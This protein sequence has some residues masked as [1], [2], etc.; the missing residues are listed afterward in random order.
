MRNICLILFALVSFSLAHAQYT[1]KE[2]KRIENTP[3]KSQ[4]RTGTCW[5]FATSSFLESE[6]SRL[7]GDKVDLSE[8]Y[9]VKQN[10]RDKAL[11]Y[12]LRQGNARFSQG[13]LS[14]DVIRIAALHGLVPQQQLTGFTFN[15]KKYDH[16]ELASGLKGYLDGV[17]K[18]R[19]ITPMWD[20][21]VDA[22]LDIYIG[23]EPQEFQYKGE[24]YTPKSFAEK[25]GFKAE[26]YVSLTSFSHHP[27]Y[28]EFILEIPDN[29]SNGEFYNIPLDVFVDVVE[30]ALDKGYS[31]AWDG[32]VSEKSFGRKEGIAILPL[33]VNDDMFK[34][35]VKEI[36]VN[37][38]NRQENFMSY[39]TTDDH[40]MHLIGKAQDQEGN[41]Y[42][43]IKNSWGDNNPYGGYLYMS[44]AYF[45]MKTVAIM[46]NKNA[47]SKNLLDK[48]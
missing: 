44:K 18:Q 27:F 1:F 9:I 19:K 21:V 6:V 48:I 28:E 11:N 4:G 37:Q 30:N 36:K 47:L 24:T 33:T 16:A 25:I 10:Y 8:M 13:S 5:S 32:D 20:Q 38:S 43:I 14:H 23:E 34:N 22:I 29:Y 2:L 26:D 41:E 31:I 35:P 42:Y 7:V 45:K 46:V 40:L 3:V 17:I 12:V 15:P 39:A